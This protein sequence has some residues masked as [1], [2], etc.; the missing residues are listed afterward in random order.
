[1]AEWGEMS[2]CSGL[3]GKRTKWQAPNSILTFCNQ[4][5]HETS[6]KTG[7]QSETRTGFGG[8]SRRYCESFPSMIKFVCFFL[9][10]FRFIIGRTERETIRWML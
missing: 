8:I 3:R 2:I 5:T 6:Q 9:Y 4:N 7:F 10:R 1:M